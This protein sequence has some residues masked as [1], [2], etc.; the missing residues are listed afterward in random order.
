MFVLTSIPGNQMPEIG[1][2]NWDKLAHT[3]VYAVLAFLFVR[4]LMLQKRLPWAKACG[5]TLV[6]GFLYAGVDELHQLMIP[7]RACTWQDLIA[8]SIGILAGLF[9]VAMPIYKKR[10]AV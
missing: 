5:Y 7:N 9:V 2:W 3:F 1:V 10:K 6:M 4:Y 8:D